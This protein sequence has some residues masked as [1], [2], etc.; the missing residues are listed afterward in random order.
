M[1]SKQ[2]EDKPMKVVATQ[3]GYYEH[4]RRRPG[5]QFMLKSEKHF[6]AKW[7]AKPQEYRAMKAK[8]KEAE[9]DF[10]KS[11]PVDDVI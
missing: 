6:C 3:L 9:T 4:A 11:S 8:E 1:S 10:S 7:M 5:H 2:H